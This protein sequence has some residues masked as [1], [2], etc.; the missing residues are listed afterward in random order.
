MK[1]LIK[2]PARLHMGLIDM[3]GELGR[4]FGGLGVGIDHPNVILEAQPAEKF[5]I[6]GKETELAAA[7]A[8]QFFNAYPTKTN[9][10]LN[11]RQAIPAHVGLGS[12]TQ[13]ALSIATAL[14]KVLD[15]KA[16]TLPCTDIEWNDS[17]PKPRRKRSSALTAGS[18]FLTTPDSEF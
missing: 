18:Y 1:V 10:H 4:L 11:I 3:N 12:G 2:T 14:A 7:L 9:V 8:K 17:S 5:S 15:S 6:I 13:L 16:S